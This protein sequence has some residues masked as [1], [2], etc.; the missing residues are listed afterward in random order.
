MSQ[1]MLPPGFPPPPQD[2]KEVAKKMVFVYYIHP[3]Q[4][5]VTLLAV[6]TIGQRYAAIVLDWSCKP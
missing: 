5:A 2:F 1:V 4:L 6:Q 3:L